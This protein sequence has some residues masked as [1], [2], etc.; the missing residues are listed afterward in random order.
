MLEESAMAKSAK[1]VFVLVVLSLFFAKAGFADASANLTTLPAI[2]FHGSQTGLT[3]LDKNIH[4]TFYYVPSHYSLRWDRIMPG[5]PGDFDSDPWNSYNAFYDGG[6]LVP[7]VYGWLEFKHFRIE[8]GNR[9]T[10][11]AGR[12]N[13]SQFLGIG[14]VLRYGLAGWGNIGDQAPQINVV[15]HHEPVYLALGV[16]N[17]SVF[18]LPDAE[19]DLGLVPR[20]HLVGGIES[21]RITV[22]PNVTLMQTEVDDLPQ[23]DDTVP[24]W[25]VEVPF[26]VH[27][28]SFGAKFSAHYGINVGNVYEG[29]YNLSYVGQHAHGKWQSDDEGAPVDT[30]GYGG[31]FDLSFGGEPLTMHIMGGVQVV[32]NRRWKNDD[33]NT[34]WAAVVRM[35]Y[36]L[37]SY[38][39]L[40][41][42]LGYYVF[43]N[44]V[45]VDPGE[46]KDLGSEWLGG[47]QFQFLF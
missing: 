8:A 21:D 18:S 5:Y 44:D 9:G 46:E 22:L 17:N 35:P 36:A 34:R 43:G 13:P 12:Q 2:G 40:S 45:N 28:G 26:S 33:S 10:L 16:S 15:F 38:L 29:L 19:L 25:V 47:I 30:K 3:L 11:G 32:K 6:T 41:P 1:I 14:P 20:F 39:L 42:E 23:K 27:A 4:E 37:N 7:N 31:Y 24:A